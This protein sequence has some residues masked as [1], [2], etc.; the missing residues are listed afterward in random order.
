MAKLIL[1]SASPR[2]VELLKKLDLDF[3]SIRPG[4]KEEFFSDETARSA[5]ERLARQKADSVEIDDDSLVIA[6]DTIVECAGQI[7]GKPED[8]AQA[9]AMLNLLSGNSHEVITAVCLKKYRNIYDVQSEITSVYFRN[10][11]Q[12]EIWGYI[13]TGEPFDKAGGYGIQGKG[14]I[15]VNRI[16]GCYFNVVGLP[17]SRLYDMLKKQGIGVLGV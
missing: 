12:T 6:A 9:H 7:L 4:V 14:S 16:E 13:A 17:L 11:S 2:R 3:I 10:L 8:D 5:A 1:A 15:L